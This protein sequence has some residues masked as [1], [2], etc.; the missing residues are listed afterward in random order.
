[1]ILTQIKRVSLTKIKILRCQAIKT[2]W[3]FDKS[4]IV[5]IAVWRGE[6]VERVCHSTGE[7]MEEVRHSK[8]EVQRDHQCS[9]DFPGGREGGDGSIDFIFYS[10]RRHF[11]YWFNK[12]IVRAIWL[13]C[14]RGKLSRISLLMMPSYPA[15]YQHCPE[16]INI[17]HCVT[18]YNYN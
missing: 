16:G 13:L 18:Q 1:M 9:G 14:W 10:K 7:G 2:C 15:L 17:K 4:I 8:G 11:N 6:E 5:L 3:I 12:D